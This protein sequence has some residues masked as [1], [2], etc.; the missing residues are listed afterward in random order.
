MVFYV[1]KMWKKIGE[2]VK[3]Y[4][5]KTSASRELY[6]RAKK[7][8]PGG[9]HS[10]IRFF[11]PYPFFLERGK[12]SRVWDVDGNEYID[13]CLAYG[14]AALGHAHPRIINAVKEQMERGS[15]YGMP[16]EL[17]IRFVEELKDRY[18]M[19][20]M[21]RLTSTGGD[22]TMYALRAARAYTGKDK[23]VKIE[24]HYHGA[25][26]YSLISDKPPLGKTG[27]REAPTP[28]VETTGVPRGISENVL[29]APYNNINAM[30]NIF[31]KHEGEISAVI[32]EPVMGTSSVILP[33]DGY[34]SD[35]R[36]LSE[37][38]NVVLIFDEVK[39]G[40][41][42]ARGGVCELYG[43][44]PDMVCLAKTIGGG[45]PLGAFGGKEEIMELFS[46]LGE[47]MH[48][49]TYNA[50]PAAVAAGYTA[51]K[52]ILTEETYRYLNRLGEMLLKGSRDAIEDSGV[53]ASANAVGPIGNLIFRDT[54]PID[55]RTAA[56]CD[57]EMWRAY[58]LGMLNQ[59]IIITGAAWYE[60]WF[61]SP[62]HTEE[63][64]TKTLDSLKNVLHK[65]KDES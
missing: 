57:R 41:R 21:F 4:S 7:T 53:K 2:Y 15:L 12:G 33:M 46:P 25:H 11:E 27:P 59:G 22:A 35:L 40:C 50:C 62:Q 48:F 19:M 39:T 8:T 16:H 54:P 61:I 43:V 17:A 24:G 60:P 29:V 28:V 26:D 31:R 18:P 42:V 44:D 64:I 10:P 56:A 30:E 55:Y 3:E 36:K 32:L 63:D 49:G 51:L 47:T 58:W 9:V 5:T 45:L 14:G 1:Q 34:L 52:E 6:D 65:I 20:D 13:Y 37:E 38:Y 23:I